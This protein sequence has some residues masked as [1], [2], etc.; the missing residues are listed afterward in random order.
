[1]EELFLGALALAVLAALIGGPVLALVALLRTGRLEQLDRRIRLLERRIAGLGGP[2]EDAPAASRAAGTPAGPVP[3]TAPPMT[4]ERR[5]PAVAAE[6]LPI[7]GEAVPLAAPT[8]SKPARP[9]AP[10][11]TRRPRAPVVDFDWERWVGVRGA[12][13]LGGAILALAG[14]LF[15]QYSIQRGWITPA[16]RVGIGTLAGIAALVGSRVLRRRGYRVTAD[17]LAGAGAVILYGAAWAAHSLYGLV[18]GLVALGAMAVVTAGCGLLALRH[19][20]LPIALF[21]LVGGFATPLLLSIG[22]EG[23]LGLFGYLLLLDLGLVIVGRRAGWPLL[24][25]L[26]AL[27]SFFVHGTWTVLY[28]GPDDLLPAMA[29]LGIAA[30]LF[31]VSG[32]DR[33]WLAGQA[34]ALL[35][36]VPFALHFAARAEIQDQLLPFGFLLAVLTLTAAWVSGKQR[37]PW[38]AMGTAAGAVACLAVWAVQSLPRHGSTLA[39]TAVALGLALALQTGLEIA[40]R[41]RGDGELPAA[42]GT[43]VLHLGLVAVLGLGAVLAAPRAPWPYVVGATALALAVARLGAVAGKPRAQLLGAAFLALGWAAWRHLGGDVRLE[44][45]AVAEI[46]TR[47]LFLLALLVPVLLQRADPARTW[48]LRA[49]NLA[50]LLLQGDLLTLGQWSDAPGLHLGGA[51]ALV[52]VA[53]FTAAASRSSL[54]YAA[55]ALG[56]LG[57]L[58]LWADS[59][60]NAGLPPGALILVGL[61]VLGA[62]AAA[63]ALS[64]ERLQTPL[65]GAAAALALLAAYPLL[66]ESF[67]RTGL[68]AALSSLGGEGLL[69]LPLALAAMSAVAARRWSGPLRTLHATV[70]VAFLCCAL[71]LEIGRQVAL[72]GTGACVLGTALLARSPRH[73]IL[74]PLPMVLALALAA[75]VALEILELIDQPY[76]RT[77]WPI[78]HWA[79]YVFGLPALAL[80]VAG[81]A[82]GRREGNVVALVGILLAFLWLNLEIVNL[83]ST[84]D[85]L[86]LDLERQAG[87]DLAMSVAWAL[88]AVVLLAIGVRRRAR[89]LRWVSLAF[90]LAATFK[91]FL[92]DLGELGGLYRVAS[93]IGLALTLL[94]VSLVYQRFVFARAALAAR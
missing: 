47:I 71:P 22:E 59:Y 78:L 84:G 17:A 65:A 64:R 66:A 18:P 81:P 3:P 45:S 41:R 38:L 20:S 31:A 68:A 44:T 73:E 4:A 12:A 61:G 34:G 70:A 62:I 16:L 90:L 37:A 76:P 35:L 10:G 69:P 23:P 2:P 27:G 13:L 15:F 58:G 85:A 32:A 5:E 75:I 93:L 26:G 29:F 9:P 52:G 28:L 89:G 24:G 8:P 83:F 79:G 57:T 86:D 36:P 53:V 91:V 42:G 6:P 56:W 49:M 11:K 33:R 92:Y 30:V 40:A 77:G 39:L 46:G 72:V 19:H 55:A 74:R 88:F 21:G 48:A 94:A 25:A 82:L 43:L 50:A 67:A 63:P 1:M 54:G 7:S 87:R 51:T 60:Q 14:L 80:L